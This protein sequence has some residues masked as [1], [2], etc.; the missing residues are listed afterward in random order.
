MAKW[1]IDTLQLVPGDAEKNAAN[2]E[3]LNEKGAEGWEPYHIVGITHYFKKQWTAEEE[4][5]KANK[6]QNDKK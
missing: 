4:N 3:K 6:K 5:K 1:R 2:L